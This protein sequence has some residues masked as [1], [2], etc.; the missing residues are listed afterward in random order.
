MAIVLPRPNEI[1]VEVL[2]AFAPT[3]LLKADVP[4]EVPNKTIPFISLMLLPL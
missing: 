1:Q 4:A 3:M 2:F